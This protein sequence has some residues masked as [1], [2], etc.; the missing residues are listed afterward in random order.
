MCLTMFRNN[1]KNIFLDSHT[2]IFVSS[3]PSR[4]IGSYINLAG[5]RWNSL[6]VV[7]WGINGFF[8]KSRIKYFVWRSS[9]CSYSWSDHKNIESSSS[10][11]DD[12]LPLPK[13]LALFIYTP[14]VGG[15]TFAT[16]PILSF[17]KSEVK[18]VP[19]LTISS[20]ASQIHPGV[21]KS[22]SAFNIHIACTEDTSCNLPAE[23]LISHSI[24]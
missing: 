3:N 12:P 14:G 6:F 13:N 21:T 20:V 17:T 1:F 7:L 23:S 19:S 15:S 4:R 2:S 9:W 18:R 16:K 11:T 10:S 8:F 22:H 24:F 5:R